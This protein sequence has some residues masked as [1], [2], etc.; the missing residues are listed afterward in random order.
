M[1][2]SSK[3]TELEL[4]SR[5][6]FWVPGREIST[7]IPKKS[8]KRGGGQ[9]LPPILRIISLFLCLY[10]CEGVREFLCR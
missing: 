1:S 5:K 8:E 3:T 6:L 7:E 4:L 2:Q 10:Q 9:R